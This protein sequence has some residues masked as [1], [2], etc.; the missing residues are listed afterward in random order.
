MMK[1]MALHPALSGVYIC[2]PMENTPSSH[3]A[4]FRGKEIR[5]VIYQNEWWFSVVDLL[6][7]LT[8][9]TNPKNFF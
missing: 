3:I 5:K 7:A 2:T 1:K 6:A 8:E 4:L 9:N